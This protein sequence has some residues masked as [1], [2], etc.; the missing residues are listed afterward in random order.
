MNGRKHFP[1]VFLTIFALSIF[2]SLYSVSAETENTI[3]PDIV[4][5]PL[6]PTINQQVLFSAKSS[7]YS[8]SSQYVDY[9]DNWSFHWDFGD[10]DFGTGVET[11]NT[12]KKEGRYQIKLVIT[13]EEGL[14]ATCLTAI[15]VESSALPSVPESSNSPSDPLFF[16][17]VAASFTYIFLIFAIGLI[18]FLPGCFEG[19]K[20][21][22][23][24]W[25]FVA[26]LVLVF[27]FGPLIIFSYFVSILILVFAF[28]VSGLGLV[29]RA[30]KSPLDIVL[31]V[32]GLFL[33]FVPF[34]P[35]TLNE[36]VIPYATFIGNFVI[37]WGVI[38]AVR[39]IPKSFN[40]QTSSETELPTSLGQKKRRSPNFL[41]II[42]IMIV[43]LFGLSIFSKEIYGVQE[44]LL[45]LIA[46]PGGD[47]VYIVGA[48]LGII[49]VI[50]SRIVREK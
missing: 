50:Y 1:V 28:F 32:L 19:T 20:T 40:R 46:D 23:I 35:I 48:V 5:N 30:R 29:L 36:V 33:I 18:W 26:L 15:V 3:I 37:F 27:G 41:K 8:N 47:Y 49:A 2:T 11:Y 42:Q 39:E 13:D 22:R 4:Y 44:P 14:S 7:H 17:R 16:L 6:H 9:M 25:G 21:E 12:Y 10:G 45:S 43:A 34:P 38:E 24:K 31:F